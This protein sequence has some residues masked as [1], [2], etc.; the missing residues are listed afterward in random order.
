MNRLMLLNLADISPDPEQ[1]RRNMHPTRLQELADNIKVNGVIQP[2]TVRP[3]GDRDGR[4]HYII[5]TGERRWAAS[6][7]AGNDTIQA[8]L[9]ED[10]DSMTPD[11]VFYHQL[12]EN[13][14]R[15]NLNPL[16][17][18]EFLNTRLNMLRENGCTDATSSLA[19]E[20]GTSPSWVTKSLAILKLGDD[21]RT[22]ARQGLV[23]GYP[24][25]KK[26]SALK[27]KKRQEVLQSIHDGTFDPSVLITRKRKTK[28]AP[29][30]ITANALFPEEWVKLVES[31]PYAA[32][33]DAQD[34]QWRVDIHHS[35]ERL[36]S[37]LAPSNQ[38]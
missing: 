21:I 31:T 7:L 19:N 23:R 27:G 2:I 22:I 38:G 13:L 17:K 34:P 18:A 20:L 9:S 16:E 4:P 15:E 36:R 1:P 37:L 3:A 28:Q 11:T 29:P 14:H 25:L 12:S 24:T 6:S 26:L 10:P 33:L 35:I 32:I 5:V 30:T 8:L